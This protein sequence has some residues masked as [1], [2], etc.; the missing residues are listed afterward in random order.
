MY[1]VNS[2]EIDSR[3]DELYEFVDGGGVSAP[4]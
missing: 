4:S 2:S 1:I 3:K